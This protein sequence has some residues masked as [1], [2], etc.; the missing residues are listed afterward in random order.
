MV[1]SKTLIGFLALCFSSL[2]NAALISVDDSV[3]GIDA[4]TRDTVSG[5]EWLDL[6]FSVAR[7]YNDVIT[8][9]GFG[10]DFDGWRYASIDEINSLFLSA[11]IPDINIPGD[12]AHYGTEDNAA[13]ALEL[14]TLLGP[15]YRVTTNGVTLSQI[16]GFSSLHVSSNG[17]DLIA[18]PYATVREGVRTADGL[19]SYGEVFTL[20]SSI[21]PSR[22]YEGVGSWLVRSRTVPE[23]SVLVLMLTGILGLGSVRLWIKGSDL[24]KIP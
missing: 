21:S 3:F 17:F 5:L 9:F 15:S 23:P 20:G 14:I 6:T 13:P 1:K 11:N 16:A 12:F 4:V 2:T 22:E 8:Q 18:M 10:G 19:K 7:S 24:L